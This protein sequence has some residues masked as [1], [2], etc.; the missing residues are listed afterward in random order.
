MSVLLEFKIYNLFLFMEIFLGKEE[1][2]VWTRAW[3]FS[4]L[5]FMNMLIYNKL[6]KRRPLVRFIKRCSHYI[7]DEEKLIKI[8]LKCST[9]KICV[10]AI[11]N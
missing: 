7:W 1:M 2:L 4:T 9:Q 3:V 6:N 10:N 5:A 8:I 11:A